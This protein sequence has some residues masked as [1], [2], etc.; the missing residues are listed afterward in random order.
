MLRMISSLCVPN[1]DSAPLSVPKLQT[2]NNFLEVNLLDPADP[3][4]K[5]LE[6]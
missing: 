4:L 1:S 3:S 5:L 6:S 2:I